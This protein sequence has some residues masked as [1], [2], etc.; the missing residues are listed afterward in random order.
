M[1]ACAYILGHKKDLHYEMSNMYHVMHARS[2]VRCFSHMQS[3]QETDT[4]F[5][6]ATQLRMHRAAKYMSQAE[7]GKLVGRNRQ[8]IWRYERGICPIPTDVAM[9]LIEA[10]LLPET[11][12]HTDAA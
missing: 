4:L 3:T 11:A 5:S 9:K 1:N 8:T 2:L 7:V 10:G 6:L 12:A